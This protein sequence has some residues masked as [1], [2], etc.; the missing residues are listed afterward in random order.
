M[1][2]E[3]QLTEMRHFLNRL[4]NKEVRV[5]RSSRLNNGFR[6]SY[7]VVV[8]SGSDTYSFI[9]SSGEVSIFLDPNEAEAFSAD[10]SSI[11]LMYG[12]DLITVRYA[13]TR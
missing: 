11:T 13:R 1:L 6:T 5:E 2:T 7:K 12:D 4:Q 10:S 3:D 8:Q 9:S